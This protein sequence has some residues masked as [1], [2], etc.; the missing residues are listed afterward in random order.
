M[1][2]QLW[3]PLHHLCTLPLALM[4]CFYFHLKV[5]LSPH[6]ADFAWTATTHWH[7]RGHRDER[8]FMSSQLHSPTPGSVENGLRR[9]EDRLSMTH[10]YSQQCPSLKM[11]S[12]FALVGHH[13]CSNCATVLVRQ[14]GRVP[15]YGALCAC[16][17]F[18][19]AGVESLL[20]VV[21]N[22]VTVLFIVQSLR[23]FCAHTC[24]HFHSDDKKHS[25]TSCH[26]TF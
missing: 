11:P 22:R 25:H 6:H 26:P 15:H 20:T 9:E 21:Y 18:G 16:A 24:P 14:H 19:G 12:V 5:A 17:F 2:E 7:T 4:M 8:S 23:T 1:L 3:K 13:T 10:S